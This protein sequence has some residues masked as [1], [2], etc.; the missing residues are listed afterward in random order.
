MQSASPPLTYNQVEVDLADRHKPPFTT[1]FGLF[2]YNW[3]AFGLGGAS[4]TFQRVMQTIL[5]D[6]LLEI[7]IACLDDSIVLS[8][9]IKTHLQ[10][11]EKVFC[12]FRKH[13]LKTEEEVSVLLPKGDL[14]HTV[15][16]LL[17]MIL[18]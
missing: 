5:R 11:L 3:I 2:E 6:D 12:K 7:L 17:P 15:Y 9:D 13:G 14:G 8:Q 18:P 16:L 10:C 4:A 1:L